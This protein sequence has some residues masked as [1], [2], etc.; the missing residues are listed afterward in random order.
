MANTLNATLEISASGTLARGAA[1]SAVA[2]SVQLGQNDW[3]TPSITFDDGTGDGQAN[4]WYVYQGAIAAG[5]DLD[6]DLS[7]TSLQNDLGEDIALTS[8]RALI[9]SI[10]SPASTKVIRLGPQGV[11]N[12]AQLW[13]GGVTSVCYEEV[14]DHVCR[15][16]STGGWTITAGTGDILR[17][18]NSGSASATVNLWILGT[19]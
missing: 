9:L 3:T 8:I 16:R 18:H 4:E 7:G 1:G 13:F 15:W 6:L 17:L 5:G 11:S 2:A 12:A 19:K 14:Y 10:E